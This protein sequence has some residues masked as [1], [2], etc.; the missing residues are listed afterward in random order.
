MSDDGGIGKVPASAEDSSLSIAIE[1]SLALDWRPYRNADLPFYFPVAA[2]DVLC[3]MDAGFARRVSA[4]TRYLAISAGEI[5]E[6]PPGRDRARNPTK[7]V[8]KLRMC[9][10]TLTFSSP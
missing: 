6:P 8:A 1:L 7:E 3:P 2:S 5:I 4:S 10:I 9:V